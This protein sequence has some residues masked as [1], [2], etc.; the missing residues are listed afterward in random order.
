MIQIALLV[1][2]VAGD[3]RSDQA[4][5]KLVGVKEHDVQVDNREHHKTPGQRVVPKVHHV[6]AAQ[7]DAGGSVRENSASDLTGWGAGGASAGSAGGVDGSAGNLPL[8]RSTD[9]SGAS[10]PC[11]IGRA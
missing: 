6:A 2:L 11:K 7:Q 5:A 8:S 4:V 9:S 1:E 10:R 3:D